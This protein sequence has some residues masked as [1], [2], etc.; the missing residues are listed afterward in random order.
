[1]SPAGNFLSALSQTINLYETAQL[2][3]ANGEGGVWSKD[4]LNLGWPVVQSKNSEV[5][6]SNDSRAT[7]GDG[8]L[9]MFRAN[10]TDFEQVSRLIVRGYLVLHNFSVVAVD[11]ESIEAEWSPWSPKV[12]K[13]EGKPDGYIIQFKV[14]LGLQLNTHIKSSADGGGGTVSD[15]SV[16]DISPGHVHHQTAHTER[17]KTRCGGQR[18][19][20]FL[21]HLACCIKGEDFSVKQLPRMSEWQCDYVSTEVRVNDGEPSVTAATQQTFPTTPFTAYRIQ[22]RLVTQ[23]G[24]YGPSQTLLS[25]PL[26]KQ[27]YQLQWKPPTVT[28]GIL[29]FYHLRI[30]VIGLYQRNC[31]E[32]QAPE[33]VNVSVPANLTSIEVRNVTAAPPP[34]TNLTV[35]NA[36]SQQLLVSWLPPHP[37]NGELERYVVRV[38]P[39]E[40][41]VFPTN[42]TLTPGNAS[43]DSEVRA[44]HHC[45]V[46]SPLLPNKAYQV[47]VRA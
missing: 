17:T 26:L 15:L 33:I 28:N 16:H 5:K 13:G 3:N 39:V 1:M 19:Q 46:L 41:D 42:F 36:S 27:V 24:K 29:R 34:P 31:P 8:G 2:K 6:F 9:Y 47:L 22:A 44:G 4:G 45:A 38:K 11:E 25:S 21:F 40:E 35:Y 12:D 14:C 37:P 10:G 18:N 32:F 20:L 7:L 23:G 30:R 43:C